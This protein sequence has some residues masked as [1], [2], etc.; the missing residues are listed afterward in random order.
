[1]IDPQLFQTHPDAIADAMRKRGHPFDARA[2]EDAFAAKRQAALAFEAAQA[3]RN[4]LAREGAAARRKGADPQAL[5]AQAEAAKAQAEL[6]K[7]ELERAQARWRGLAMALPNLPAPGVPEGDGEADNVVLRQHGQPPAMD[8]VPKTHDELGALHRGLDFEAGAALAGARFAVIAGPLAR[9]HRALIQFMLDEHVDAHGYLEIQ[10]PFLV[11]AQ[12]LEG[13]GQLPKFEDDL[14]KL[15]RDGLYLI[16]TAEVPVTNLAAGMDLRR[17]QL[18]LAF[19]CHT[20]CFRRE[21]GSAGRDVK[22]LIRQRQ[23]EKVELV[24]VCAPE[25]AAAQFAL[26]LTHAQAILAKLGLPFRTVELCA[27]DLGFASERTVDLE[28]WLPGQ[29]AWREISSVSSFGQ[30]QARRM[31]AKF[32]DGDGKRR[33]AATLNGSGLAAGRTLVA[34][35]ENFQRA[36]GSIEVPQAL[37]PYMNGACELA[38]WGAP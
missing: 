36:D 28:V 26:I 19:A 6:A 17:E 3:L 7:E 18:P 30:F 23:F 14:F 2:F 37:R 10:T 31:G 21:A 5:K 16:P 33:L 9:L 22:G 8:F 13:T 38:P 35:M 32:R 11:K 4:R 24:R 34:V 20:P 27:G 25:D 15:E 1:M 12:A 29:N